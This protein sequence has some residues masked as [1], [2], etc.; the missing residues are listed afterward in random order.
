MTVI[1]KVGESLARLEGV[2]ALTDVTGFGLLGHTLEM[3]RGSGLKAVLRVAHVPVLPEVGY[4]LSQD[5]LPGGIFRNLRSYGQY[6]KGLTEENQKVLA[7]PQT[8]GGLLV[9]VSPDACEEYKEIV[10]QAGLGEYAT[11]PFGEMEAGSGI[12]LV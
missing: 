6:V 2:R 1:N 11:R 7:D 8:S 10:R 12:E 4:Y 9:A 3:A 5:C